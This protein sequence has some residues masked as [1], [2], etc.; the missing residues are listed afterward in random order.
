MGLIV[1]NFY[2]LFDQFYKY[3]M[4]IAYANIFNLTYGLQVMVKPWNHMQCLAQ[5]FL[6]AIV[7]KT[8]AK[9][10]AIFIMG[11]VLT[12]QKLSGASSDPIKA[13]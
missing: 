3:Q 10:V 7:P 1:V 5:G 8:N 11:F 13:S 6:L 12:Y 4:T 2:L 9:I